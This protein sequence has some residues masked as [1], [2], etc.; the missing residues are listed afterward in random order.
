MSRLRCEGNR[1]LSPTQYAIVMV[2]YDVHIEEVYKCMLPSGGSKLIFWSA[3][4]IDVY[5]VT[6][7]FG[8]LERTLAQG[9]HTRFVVLRF[10]NRRSQGMSGHQLGGLST[11]PIPG[12]R[13][14]VPGTF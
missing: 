2:V 7:D 14:R 1:T 11:A 3:D 5:Y 6:S 4:D 12:T 10:T 13:Y 9:G 8:V